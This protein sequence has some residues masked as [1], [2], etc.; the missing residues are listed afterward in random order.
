MYRMRDLF[1]STLETLK[2][3]SEVTHFLYLMHFLIGLGFAASIVNSF[4]QQESTFGHVLDFLVIVLFLVLGSIAIFVRHLLKPNPII[5]VESTKR[6]VARFAVDLSPP[7]A[8]TRA[9]LAILREHFGNDTMPENTFLTAQRKNPNCIVVAK[10]ERGEIVGIGDFHGLRDDIFEKFIAGSIG[11]KEF[12]DACFLT[13]T[14]LGRENR[15]Y[16][17]GVSVA[18]KWRHKD[19]EISQALMKGVLTAIYKT[20]KERSIDEPNKFKLDIYSLGY[21]KS[22]RRSLDANGFVLVGE[23]TTQRSSPIFSRSTT[24]REL[25]HLKNKKPIGDFE[26]NVIM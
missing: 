3:F 1:A 9:G 7:P 24:L 18:K 8:D 5:L 26:I 4:A 13:Q 12:F 17:G 21:T 15:V 6:P 11:E 10:T 25:R 16:L 2:T 23:P 22:G 14:E 20:F 19:G